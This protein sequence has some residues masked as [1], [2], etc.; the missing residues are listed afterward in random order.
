MHVDAEAGDPRVVE[1]Q[2]PGWIGTR[3]RR[4]AEV[5]GS[6]QPEAENQF[7][8]HCQQRNPARQGR[9]EALTQPAQQA[10]DEGDQD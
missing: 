3:H 10:A 1:F 7:Q 5:A 6:P 2:G 4:V 9:A 8:G